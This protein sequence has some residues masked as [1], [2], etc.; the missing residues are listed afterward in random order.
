MCVFLG[1]VG[2]ERLLALG[3]KV[4][5]VSCPVVLQANTSGLVSGIYPGTPNSG[6]PLW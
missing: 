5:V 1:G 6:T 3:G 4:L 2:V